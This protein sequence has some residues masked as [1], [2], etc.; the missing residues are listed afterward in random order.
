MIVR[1]AKSGQEGRAGEGGGA[2][3]GPLRISARP[4]NYLTKDRRMILFVRRDTRDGS[5]QSC[6][7]FVA[8][9]TPLLRPIHSIRIT[10]RLLRIMW[11][12]GSATRERE[13][14]VY[15]FVIETANGDTGEALRPPVYSLQFSRRRGGGVKCLLKRA[16]NGGG[17]RKHRN[18]DIFTRFKCS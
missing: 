7:P 16:I 6:L 5:L 15:K 3:Q 12:S 4:F 9:C 8:Q 1:G 2:G 17:N 11:E 14:T 13:T 18:A 10:G